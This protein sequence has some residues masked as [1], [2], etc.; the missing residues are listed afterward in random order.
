MLFRSDRRHACRKLVLFLNPHTDLIAMHIDRPWRF[1]AQPNLSVLDPQHH[2][3][4]VRTDGYT[5]TAFSCQDQHPCSPIYSESSTRLSRHLQ[6]K[7]NLGSQAR[8]EG[9]EARGKT[10]LLITPSHWPRASRLNIGGCSRSVHESYGLRTA[11][12]GETS[13]AINQTAVK[14]FG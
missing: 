11:V 1:D 5:F 7:L 8:G 9:H 2:D 12:S 4:D 13:E 6:S 3:P 14:T 10:F